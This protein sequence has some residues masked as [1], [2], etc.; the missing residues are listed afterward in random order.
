MKSRVTCALLCLL[1]D[2]CLCLPVYCGLDLGISPVRWETRGKPGKTLRQVVVLTG[3][4]A[5][6]QNIKIRVGDWTLSDDGAPVYGE[7]GRVMDESAL[8]WVRVDPGQLSIYP[9]Q[10][11]TVRISMHIP[12]K[13]AS[14]GYRA[15]VFFEPEQ[16]SGGKTKGATASVFV[17]GRMA[18]PIYVTVGDARP[19]GEILEASW[20]ADHGA[21]PTPALRVHNR[22]NAHLRMNGIFSASTFSEKRLEGIIPAVP[23]LPGRTRWIPLTFRGQSPTPFSDVHLKLLVD[24]GDGETEVRIVARGKNKN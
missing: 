20:R 22:G 18:L 21:V 23:V 9:R 13:T 19:R 14:A 24:L 5:A 3:G 11:K 4:G 8:S 12:D 10:R 15:A 7:A 2:L 6:I 1:I 17:T 16:E